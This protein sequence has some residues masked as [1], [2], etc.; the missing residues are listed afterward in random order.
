MIVDPAIAA[1]HWEQAAVEQLEKELSEQ[2][3]EVQR[4]AWLGKRRADLIARRGDR[5]TVYEFKVVGQGAPRGWADQVV[6][7]RDEVRAEGGRFELVV[8]RPPRTIDITIDGIE[9]ALQQALMEEVPR[10][11]VEISSRVTI[12]NVSDVDL[13]SLEWR[14]QELGVTGDA[15]VQVTLYSEGGEACATEN[16]PFS[17][18]ARLNRSNHVEELSEVE[19]DLS[20]WTGE[21]SSD[22]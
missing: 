9:R 20:S 19:I 21:S 17:F 6:A 15:T 10:E 4:D 12:D 14:D 13:S 7:L 1:R 3:Y 11:L 8:V 22:D 5:F 18:H 16:F 2:G